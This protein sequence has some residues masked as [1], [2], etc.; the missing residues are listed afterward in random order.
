MPDLTRLLERNRAWSRR[1]T[2]ADP[3]FFRALATQQRPEILWIGCSDSRVPANQIVGLLPGDVFV[4]R[5][6]ANVVAP[7]DLNCLSVLQFAVDVLR[8]RHVVVCGHYG[9]GGV[10][11]VDR[12]EKLGL[13]DDW[14][15]PVR[16]V[17][18]RHGALLAALSGDERANLL[19]ALNVL[20]QARHAAETSIV[21]GAW[22]RGQELSV[23]GWIYGIEDGLLRDL[24]ATVS[25]PDEVIP[26]HRAAIAAASSAAAS[27]AA[28]P[29]ATSLAAASPPPSPREASR[30]APPE[31]P[32][33][34]RRA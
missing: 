29:S 9:C 15:R 12:E 32:E 20:D 28:E 10:G 19:C 11:A 24:G 5:N 31:G 27:S 8:V 23:H 2:D 14:L 3:S 6:V 16:D 30:A 22:N 25:T 7:A 21:A 17:R 13:V 1:M 34:T 33:P 4:H 26:V 18:A